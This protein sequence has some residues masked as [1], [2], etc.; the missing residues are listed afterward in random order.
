MPHFS[1]CST[2]L[3]LRIFELLRMIGV[4][5]CL[6]SLV[7]L[8]TAEMLEKLRRSAA[9]QVIATRRSCRKPRPSE[10]RRDEPKVD[11]PRPFHY[12]I[13]STGRNAGMAEDIIC[14]IGPS[15]FNVQCVF[16]ALRLPQRTTSSPSCC[17]FVFLSR[18]TGRLLP[19]V[20]GGDTTTPP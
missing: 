2:S 20:L 5:V 1:I 14:A 3:V 17:H 12:T 11:A 18:A 6:P 16:Q 8:R 4:V 15:L 9:R 13:V 7:L 10:T 19:S